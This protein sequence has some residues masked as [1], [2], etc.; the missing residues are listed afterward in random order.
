[1]GIGLL[2]CNTQHRRMSEMM[3][4]EIG[5]T[6]Y[7]ENLNPQENLRDE[8]YRL[9][10]GFALGYINLGRGRDLR[11][12]HDMQIVERLLVLAVGTKK[13]DLVHILDKATA[14]ATIAIAL[15]F[16][17][18]GD[19]ALAR[20]IDVPDTIHQFDYVR[21][22]VLLLRTVARHLIMWD[23]ICPSAEWMQ[24]QLP[25]AFQNRRQLDG[26]S[27]SSHELPYMNILAGLCLSLGL[28]YAGTGELEVR[29]LLCHQLD[30]FIWMCRLP[31]TT[32]DRRLTRIT[33]RNCQDTVALAAACVMA[34]TGDLQV[35]RRLRVLHGRTD[36][37]TPYGSHLAAHLA[38]GVLF[39]GGGTHSF[40]TSNIAVASLLCAFYP[41]FPTSVLD[42]K[43]HLQAFRH[44]WALAAEPRC[45]VVRHV[46]THRPLP[47][48]VTVKLRK[49]SL[50]YPMTA[51]CLLPELDTVATIVT[52]DQAHW[53][54]T[55]NL[56]ENPNQLAA[57]KRH[58]NIYVRRRPA[59]DANGS[60]FSATMLALN[61]VQSANQLGQQVLGWIFTLPVFEGFD[62]TEQAQVL[63]PDLANVTHHAS[64]GTAVDDCLVLNTACMESGR[65]ERLWNLRLLF[66]WADT[67]AAR[68]GR[69]GWLREEVIM[70]LRARLCLKLGAEREG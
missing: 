37:E 55:L 17:K 34:G 36:A 69:W 57:F 43:S 6:D 19:A 9:A 12:L 25:P 10:A 62:R 15:I 53:P 61:D 67:L 40:G 11:G 44:F 31:S 20:K 47:L 27:V 45:L 38:I 68:S 50:H 60:V 5:N 59:G 70:R 32:Y 28:R 3:L 58:Q 39:L 4:S 21:P 46:D 29:N 13:A 64:R 2:Y 49:S 16:M 24:Q 48:A 54:V 63:P 51:P 56:A 52:S 42:N 66:A 30:Q 65:S 41:L 14:A 35:L 18:T 23:Q 8:G 33:A 1:M 26:R 22:D 7:E